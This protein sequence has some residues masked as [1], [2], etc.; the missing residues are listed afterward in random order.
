[1]AYTALVLT[2]ESRDFLLER[3]P[4]MY[5]ETIAHHITMEFG[6]PAN[7]PPPEVT[8]VK[9]VGYID[10]GDGLEAL[11]CSVDGTTIRGDAGSYHITWSLEPHLYK[12]VDS[13]QIIQEHGHYN[14]SPLSVEFQAQTLGYSSTLHNT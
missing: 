8:Y 6:V 5:S 2:K 11:L 12:P 10:S 4:P 9:V 3:F 14:V 1:M 7:T 13:N